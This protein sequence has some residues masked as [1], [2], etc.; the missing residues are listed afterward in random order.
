MAHHCRLTAMLGRQL[1]TLS[2]SKS[3]FIAHTTSKNAIAP[4][5]LVGAS[6]S[7]SSLVSNFAADSLCQKSVLSNSTRT[8]DLTNIQTNA[9]TRNFSSVAVSKDEAYEDASSP[10]EK[11]MSSYVEDDGT[12][13]IHPIL[14]ESSRGRKKLKPSVV[15][16]RINKLRTYIG[17]EKGIRHSPWRMN[18]VCQFAAGQTV[19][20][21]LTQLEF[22][23]KSH[24]PL[25]AKVIRRTANLAD[26]RDGLQYSQLEVAECFATHGTH[27][28]RLKIMGRGRSGTKRRRHSHIRLVLR[29]IDFQLKIA[30]AKTLNQ[31]KRWAIKRALAEAEGETAQAEREEIKQLE[32]EAEKR[33]VAEEATKGKK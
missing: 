30:Q 19:N 14:L 26:I 5:F 10:S 15:Q 9:I 18:L 32:R 11:F 13:Y 8:E 2:I 29:E 4:H 27:L 25:L 28:K 6:R 16:R 12:V 21:A 3:P 33:R 7:V 1:S 22:C 17:A 31:K 20:E 23:E 24:A